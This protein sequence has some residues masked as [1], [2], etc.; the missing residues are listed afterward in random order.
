MQ[1]KIANG[2]ALDSPDAKEIK[3]KHIENCIINMRD[4]FTLGNDKESSPGRRFALINDNYKFSF[5]K[6]SLNGI[7]VKQLSTRWMKMNNFKVVGKDMVE[8]VD[9]NIEIPKSFTLNN[10]IKK[11]SQILKS[12]RMR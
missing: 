10:E 8:V 7:S 1:K 3:S 6:R 2:G 11:W 4:K 5:K 9:S 12:K